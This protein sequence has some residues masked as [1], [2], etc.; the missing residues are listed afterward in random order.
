MSVAGTCS[1][2]P[3]SSVCASLVTQTDQTNLEASTESRS[4]Y[5]SIALMSILNTNSTRKVQR[6]RSQQNQYPNPSQASDDEQIRPGRK[7]QLK[8]LIER[9]NRH[10]HPESTGAITV[11][12]H[13]CVPE[14]LAVEQCLSKL[15]RQELLKR[16]DSL[17]EQIGAFAAGRNRSRAASVPFRYAGDSAAAY[18]KYNAKYRL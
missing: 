15:P 11:Q 3:I 17:R 18:A 12:P 2:G 5:S 4:L 10:A 14:L 9:A 6:K 8:A 13:P 7:Q 16:R 1:T